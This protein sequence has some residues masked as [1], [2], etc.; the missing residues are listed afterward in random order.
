M[1]DP[2]FAPERLANNNALKFREDIEGLR[3]VAVVLVLAYHFGL[4]PVTGGYIGVDIFFVISGFLITSFLAK[5][6]GVLAPLKNFY[7]RRA[8][9]LLPLVVVFSVATTIAFAFVLLPEDLIDYLRSLRSALSFQSNYWFDTQTKD[10]FAAGSREMPLLHTWSLSIEW[11]FYICFPLAYLCA[12][13]ILK[14]RQ[15]FWGLIFVTIIFAAVSVLKTHDSSNAY[16]LTST[17]IFELLI[18]S[19][20]AHLN[21]KKWQAIGKKLVLPAGTALCLLASLLNVSSVFPGVNAIIVCLFTAVLILFGDGNRLLSSTPFNYIGRRSYSIYLWH[22]PFIA[23]YAYMHIPASLWLTAV[24]IAIVLSLAHFSYSYIEQPFRRARSGASTTMGYWF[25]TPL[26]SV[27]IVLW[28]T[29]DHEGFPQRLGAESVYVH[30]ATYPNLRN[31]QRHCHDFSGQDIE[32]CSFGERSAKTKALLIGD[33]HARHYW[34]FI[35]VLAKSGKLKVTGL[36]ERNCLAIPDH[37]FPKQDSSPTP[38]AAAAA[39]NFEM[40]RSNTFDYVIIGEQWTRYAAEK[41][42]YLDEAIQTIIAS[43]AIPVILMQFAADGE[44]KKR[45]FFA[46]IK[47]RTEYR[48]ECDINQQNFHKRE[49][50][51]YVSVLF[52]RIRKKYPQVVFIDPQSVQCEQQRCAADIDGVGVYDDAHHINGFGST[53]FAHRYLQ[54]FGNPLTAQPGKDLR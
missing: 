42:D 27:L 19:C 29:R 51:A 53:T 48:N 15:L 47:F 54:R 12:K 52:D 44:N 1:S 23:F 21:L 45:C 5:E 7:V 41:L 46:H 17:R 18:G 16:F 20:L 6:T 4:P 36:T 8:K 50:K 11:Q 10:Y 31:N 43:R 13:S 3:A 40:V 24:T 30:N 39:R 34:W 32:A 25:A 49:A 33:S 38:C 37:A 28:I 14:P 35:D 2:T 9:R 22:W 26:A